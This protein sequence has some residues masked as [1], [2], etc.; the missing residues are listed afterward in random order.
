MYRPAKIVARAEKRLVEYGNSGLSTMCRH[1]YRAP[2]GWVGDAWC[3][4]PA[5]RFVTLSLDMT[6][7]A[8]SPARWRNWSPGSLFATKAE[9]IAEAE[10]LWAIDDEYGKERRV[11][12]VAQTTVVQIRTCTTTPVEFDIPEPERLDTL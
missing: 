4:E 11:I 6:V 12:Y 7:S 9:A 1:A 3:A 5:P 10:R 8:D 2:N